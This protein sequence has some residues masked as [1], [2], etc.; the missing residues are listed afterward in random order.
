MPRTTDQQPPRRVVV[1][2]ID[3][4]MAAILRQKSMAEKIAMV[5]AAHR[6]ARSLIRCGVKLQHPDWTE[7]EVHDEVL[8][9]LLNGTT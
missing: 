7:Q 6:T 1:E 5:G 2:V 4:Q 9:R 3:E 8:R